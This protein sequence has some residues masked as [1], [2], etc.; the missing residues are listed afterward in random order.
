[1]YF[2]PSSIFINPDNEKVFPAAA[3]ELL[4]ISPFL[5][6]VMFWVMIAG[7][8]VLPSGISKETTCWGE[9]LICREKNSTAV[10]EKGN[11]T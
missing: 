5:P 6:I 2:P 11:V 9:P 4:T 7:E 8:A 3:P 10:F 1:M